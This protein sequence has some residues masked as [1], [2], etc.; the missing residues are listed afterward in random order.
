M[1]NQ[2]IEFQPV[3]PKDLPTK[4]G[5]TGTLVVQAL[6]HLGKNQV[7]ATVIGHLHKRLSDADRKALLRDT[8]Y[9]ADWI[10]E[11]AKQIASHG[12]SADG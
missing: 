11:V 4:K 8:R 5:T 6:R 7:D 2:T 9:A 10:Y 1:G 3:G 12:D